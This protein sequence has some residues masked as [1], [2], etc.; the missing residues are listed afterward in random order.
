MDFFVFGLDEMSIAAE[1]TGNIR[2]IAFAIRRSTRGFSKIGEM[3]IFLFV[4][5]I[6]ISYCLSPT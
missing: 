4:I 5:C 1:H 2:L 3:N 6:I